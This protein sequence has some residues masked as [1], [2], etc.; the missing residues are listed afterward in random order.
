MHQIR[1]IFRKIRK[2]SLKKTISYPIFTHFSLDANFDEHLGRM[3]NDSPNPNVIMK[4]VEIEGKPYLCHQALSD[5]EENVEIRNN[6]GVSG[7]WR[8]KK[9]TTIFIN[10]VLF[11]NNS[12]S[13][14]SR[15]KSE[16]QH[17]SNNTHVIYSNNMYCRFKV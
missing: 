14:S 3:I 16:N 5:I 2:K 12:K 8:R 15:E 13:C 17:K 1:I 4:I 9:V 11:F 10:N 6:Y 7:L